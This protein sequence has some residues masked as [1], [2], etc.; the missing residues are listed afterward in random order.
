[1]TAQLPLSPFVIGL[2]IAP[3]G[4]LPDAFTRAEQV[5]INRIQTLIDAATIHWDVSEV[6]AAKVTLGGNR[7]LATPTGLIPGQVYALFVVAGGHTLVYSAD[8]R[9][10]GGSAP[11]VSGTS[12]I[13]FM[14]DGTLM[15]GVPQL[16][17]A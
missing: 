9:W 11:V 4:P 12:I 5:V 6:A 13:S 16:G 2:N 1:V 15:Y 14:T 10:V 8:Y 17:F 3:G 7:T